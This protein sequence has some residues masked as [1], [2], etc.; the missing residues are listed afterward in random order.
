MWGLWVKGRE[1]GR[2]TSQQCLCY[3]GLAETLYVSVYCGNF[4]WD[5]VIL[6]IQI[7][8]YLYQGGTLILTREVFIFNHLLT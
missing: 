4:K 1:V 2:E 6:G 8:Q 7:F 5:S 3:K